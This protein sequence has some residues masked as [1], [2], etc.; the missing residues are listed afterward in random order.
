VNTEKELR[1]QAELLNTLHNIDTA[2]LQAHTLPAIAQAALTRL[3]TLAPFFGASV[4]LFEEQGQGTVLYD[5]YHGSPDLHMGPEVSLEIFGDI[6]DLRQG[7]V[8]AI[9]DT[10]TSPDQ[11]AIIERL[12][13]IGLRAY[14]SVP[15]ITQGALV[16]V[17]NLGST[18]PGPFPPQWVNL[19]QEVASSMAV[20]TQQTRLVDQVKEA[21]QE[22]RELSRRV[23]TA[24]EAERRRISREL[25]DEASQALM[26]VKISLD[27]VR[28]KLPPQPES[29][30]QNIR[31]AQDLTDETMDAIRSLAL[32][33]RPPELEAVGLEPVLVDYCAEFARRT[34]LQ[35]SYQGVKLPPLPDEVAISL[36]RVLQEA[37]TNVIKH[38]HASQ[39]RV[40]LSYDQ[41]EIGLSVIDDGQGFVLEDGF[42][43][44]HNGIGT[45]GM[46]ERLEGLGGRLEIETRPAQGT[47]LHACVPWRTPK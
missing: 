34:Q 23:F 40:E 39:V 33:L 6:Q 42:H 17:L 13:D 36:Y 8:Y 25:H 16:G 26:A 11:D 44:T 4:V 18:R 20:A 32:G 22:L 10:Q 45:I 14:I 12:R 15:L 31:A 5:H 30:R 27:M 37:L 21:S 29:L 3:V 41:G 1:F 47:R 43:Q 2:I 7:K 24:Q 19:A 38:A 9:E 46:R 35:V 28:K